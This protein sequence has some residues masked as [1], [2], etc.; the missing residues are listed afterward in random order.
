MERTFVDVGS[1]VGTSPTGGGR[2]GVGTIGAE[3]AKSREALQGALNQAAWAIGNGIKDRADGVVAYARREPVS[4]LSAAAGVG[5]LV[6]LGV[7]IAS[8]GVSGRPGDWLS[9]SV[10]GR[11]AVPGW[12]RFLRLG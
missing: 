4:A 12:R 7:A 3:L 9:L 11:R 6:G 1:R 2:D 8:R 10:L 5:M